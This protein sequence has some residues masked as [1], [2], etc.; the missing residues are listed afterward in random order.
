MQKERKH[1]V[2][3]GGYIPS[4]A[5]DQDIQKNCGEN[6]KNQLLEDQTSFEDQILSQIPKASLEMGCLR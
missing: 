4:F 6:S 5:F 3:T 2:L 1:Q